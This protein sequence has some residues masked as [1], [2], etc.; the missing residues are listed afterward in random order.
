M[1]GETSKWG[2]NILEGKWW[3]DS[4]QRPEPIISVWCNHGHNH[5]H[6]QP[7]SWVEG[8]RRNI[9]WKPWQKTDRSA[10]LL[11]PRSPLNA[12]S[13][14][15]AS[16]LAMARGHPHPQ[17]NLTSAK[18]SHGHH[19]VYRVDQGHNGRHREGSDNGHGHGSVQGDTTVGDLLTRPHLHHH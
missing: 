12:T 17:Q 3:G 14:A 11:S 4:A 19:D 16:S 8:N 1:V 15:L 7:S 9:S 5:G 2:S 18:P 6:C 13:L 10:C